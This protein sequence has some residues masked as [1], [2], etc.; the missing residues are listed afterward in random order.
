MFCCHLQEVVVWVELTQE[1][2][3]QYKWVQLS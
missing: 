2:R 3:E 1:Q